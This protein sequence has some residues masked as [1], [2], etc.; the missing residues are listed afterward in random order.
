MLNWKHVKVITIV[1]SVLG[2]CVMIG[3]ILQVLEAKD[4]PHGTFAGDYTDEEVADIF[5]RTRDIQNGIGLTF[6]GIVLVGAFPV[7]YLIKRFRRGVQ[8]YSTGGTLRKYTPVS[9]STQSMLRP[10]TVEKMQK[11]VLTL[12][13]SGGGTTIPKASNYEFNKGEIV[14][15]NAISDPGWEFSGWTGDVADNYSESTSVVINS[16]K[17]VIASFIKL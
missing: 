3:G 4:R 8:E 13:V 17:T 11:S 9:Q 1:I 6:L 2:L 7:A 15:I 16:D 14:Y 12:K 5:N 10:Q